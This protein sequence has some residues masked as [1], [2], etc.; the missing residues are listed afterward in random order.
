MDKLI[1]PKF[2][3]EAEEAQWW[4]DH[5]DVV[6][7]NLMEA[8]EKGTAHTGG[9]ARVLQERRESE[10]ITIRVPIADIE[11][12]REQAERKGL[13]YQTYIKML[14]HEALERQDSV[15]RS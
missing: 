15:S 10:E 2:E 12:A 3:T 5:M 11:R 7:D 8:I 1:V 4:D 13:G 6:E 14:L 9:P